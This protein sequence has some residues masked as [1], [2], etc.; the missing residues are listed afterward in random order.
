MD[1]KGLVGRTTVYRLFIASCVV[2]VCFFIGCGN[3]GAGGCNIDFTPSN[4][5]AGDNDNTVDNVNDNGGTANG[6]DN[7]SGNDNGA[8]GNE[9]EN[10]NLN[11]NGTV[12]GNENTNGGGTV[13]N[14]NGTAGGNDNGTTGGNDNGT[15]GGND[16][17]TTNANDNTA[18]NENANTNDNT[19]TGGGGGGGDNTNTNTGPQSVRVKSSGAAQPGEMVVLS[20]EEDL[21]AACDAATLWTQTAGPAALNPNDSHADGSFTFTAPNVA[22]TTNLSFRVDIP[23]NCAPN[24]PA[25]TANLTVPVQVAN[26]VFD[27]PATIAVNSPLSLVN[28]TSV[29][30]APADFLTLYFSEEPL[31]QGVNL[32]INQFDRTLT[33][34]SGV[35]QTVEITVQV[36]AA[37]GLLAQAADTIQIV[38]AGP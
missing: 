17:G 26:V 15:T 38:A 9:N 20:L 11:D 24:Q 35:G 28:F 33:V 22:V 1:V 18:G 25:R 12:G 30:G 34:S 6:N 16:N 10:L 31:P 13:G 5:N 4:M 2:G 29:S 27:L 23:A 21:P 19:G 3:M 8:A 7:T 36:F 14:D 37:S 32:E